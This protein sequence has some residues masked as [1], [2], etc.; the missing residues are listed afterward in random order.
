MD[1]ELIRGNNDKDQIDSL[2]ETFSN[3]EM[4]L[5]TLIYL[6]IY[7]R[8]N[9]FFKTKNKHITRDTKLKTILESNFTEAH[10]EELNKIGLRIPM[11]QE[12]KFYDLLILTYL[13]IVFITLITLAFKNYE[14]VFVV[15]GLPI[16]GIVIAVT[17]SPLLLLLFLF[18]RKRLP[19][20]TVDE[21]IEQIIS[22]NWT[23]LMSD[24]KKLLK[25]LARDKE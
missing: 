25:E 13:A 24:D 2:I 8:I 9:K 11:L 10:W 7:R 15:W 19:C 4:E 21:L 22:I 1:K 17:C 18:K 14:L 5:R 3:P 16:I 23:E 12:P 20:D 6:A